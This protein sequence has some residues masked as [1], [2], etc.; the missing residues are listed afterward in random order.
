M[1]D[2]VAKPIPRRKRESRSSSIAVRQHEQK[3]A[4]TQAHGSEPDATERA[5]LQVVGP[6]NRKSY[7]PMDQWPG[8][9]AND[10]TKASQY[11]Y[12]MPAL[13]QPSKAVPDA[14]DMAFVSHFVQS[15]SSVATY[16]PEIPWLTHL[17]NLQSKTVKPALRLSIRATSMA[18]YATLHRDT[19]M[20]VDSFRWY[21]MSLNSQRQSLAR[22][23][24]HSIPSVEET[25]VPII[26]GLYEV[27]AGTT[28]TSMWHHLAAATKILELRGPSNCKGL[29]LPLFQA[30]RVS[31]VGTRAP[32]LSLGTRQIDT[33]PGKP[34]HGLQ[35]AL[36]ILYTRMAD[37]SIRGSNFECL[38][39]SDRYTA[40]HTWLHRHAEHGWQ[41]AQLFLAPNTIH[42]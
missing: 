35:Y 2:R 27:Y 21:A 31:A 22:L 6:P 39:T 42:S 17:P 14:L 26:L 23:G 8:R 32:G 29:I 11:Q 13:Y 16:R 7:S 10:T 28:T 33:S 30:M 20:L 4:S 36:R 24:A 41:Y 37:H 3:S 19:T 9:T 38:P 5:T 40:S 34:S 1:T 12:R 15:M 25:L 18:F